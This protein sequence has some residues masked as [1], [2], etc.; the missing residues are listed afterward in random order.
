MAKRKSIEPVAS[1]SRG[2]F[3]ATEYVEA[4]MKFYPLSESQIR[5]LSILGGIASVF[6]SVG[7][8]ALT[9]SW[10]IHF[11]LVME[12]NPPETVVAQ[13]AII[14]Y[15]FIP[16]GICLILVSFGMMIVRRRHLLKALQRESFL[17]KLGTIILRYLELRANRHRA[18]KKPEPPQT[19]P[20]S[21]T[22]SES[23]PPPSPE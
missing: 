17:Q 4:T 9:F 20:P 6:L 3:V 21:T 1:Q 23:P 11:S 16:A 19:N 8:S 10:G 13:A 18:I 22:V 15:S 7:L 2:A 5:D 12:P 14:F